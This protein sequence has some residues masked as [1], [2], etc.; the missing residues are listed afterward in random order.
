MVLEGFYHCLTSPFF[1]LRCP[2]VILNFLQDFLKLALLPLSFCMS[3]RY[4]CF[5]QSFLF[6]SNQHIYLPAF[7]NLSSVRKKTV[8]L[9]CPKLSIF[10]SKIFEF[11][12][13][14][15]TVDCSNGNIQNIRNI[16]KF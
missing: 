2:S 1:F 14:L 10:V 9:F 15:A 12:N 3:S 4:I 13:R 6:F 7:Q 5:L 8:V 11:L 16:Q